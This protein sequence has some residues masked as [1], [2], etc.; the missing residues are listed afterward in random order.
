ME[1]C[2]V[3]FIE[4]YVSCGLFYT[5]LQSV[6]CVLYLSFL[7]IV[8]YSSIGEAVGTCGILWGF[9]KDNIT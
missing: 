5:G 8:C 9:F 6:V 2:F 7:L 4:K 1:M 3:P